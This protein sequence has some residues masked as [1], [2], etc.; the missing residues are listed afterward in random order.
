MRHDWNSNYKMKKESI[1]EPNLFNTA[2]V[3]L[4]IQCKQTFIKLLFQIVYVKRLYT[5]VIQKLN[6]V[7][8]NF[9][10]RF[11]IEPLFLDFWK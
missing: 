6:K 11:Q 2:I 1:K 5:K 8:I 3:N 9:S 10:Q 4:G 7:L